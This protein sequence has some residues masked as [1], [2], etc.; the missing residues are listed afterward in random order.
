MKIA[1]V[2]L[3]GAYT[4]GMN[5][6]DNA[7]VRA[8][9]QDG[10]DVLIVSDCKS[11]D[12]G[13][14]VDTQPEDVITSNGARL[15]RLKFKHFLSKYLTEKLKI[16]PDLE[17]ILEDYR[18]DVILYHG[19]IG[20]SMLTVG[21]YKRNNP[22]TRLYLDSHEDYNNS[23][24]SWASRLFQYKILTRQL[25]HRIL[26][27]VDKIFY[28]SLETR[29]FL[30]EQLRLPD[31]C[32]EYYPLGGFLMEENE[33]QDYR[34]K[35]RRELNLD[36]DSIVFLHSGK[37]DAMKRTKWIL[38]AFAKIKDPDCRLLI[39]GDIPDSTAAELSPR[40]QADDRVVFLGWQDAESLTALMC[41]SDAY[42]QPGGQSASLQHAICCGMPIMVYPHPSHAPFLVGNG[43]YVSSADQIADEVRNWIANPDLLKAY[44][45]AS[46][47]IA[48]KLLD[49]RKL[50]ARLYEV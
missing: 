40:I 29:V 9:R 15:V 26:N 42:I 6:Q 17:T 30:K 1:H 46:Y 33:K 18:P 41:A 20:W 25:V 47:D 3:A 32:L 22:G 35:V 8:N 23:G 44:S 36:S 49:Y 12:G 28:I 48:R 43:A 11:F 10:H 37:L 34:D 31:D 14:I 21:K 2:C 5:Y 19:V 45:A 13:T 4:E 27:E 50:A 39:A 24:R 16:C 7:L 38:E